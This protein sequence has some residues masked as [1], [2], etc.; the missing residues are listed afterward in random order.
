MDSLHLCGVVHDPELPDIQFHSLKPLEE[1]TLWFYSNK[2]VCAHHIVIVYKVSLS[3][4]LQFAIRV[5]FCSC[6][7]FRSSSVGISIGFTS[8]AREL[9]L[10]KFM[11]QIRFLGR[12]KRRGLQDIRGYSN[13]GIRVR[14]NGNG[15]L[16]H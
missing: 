2:V 7:V 13:L 10:A 8:S 5:F 1:H 9:I 16:G 4:C 12:E 14:I 15:L 11:K 3:L 6:L